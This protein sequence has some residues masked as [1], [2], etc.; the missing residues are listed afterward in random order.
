MKVHELKK[1]II[2]EYKSSTLRELGIKYE[3]DPRTISKYLK[4]NGVYINPNGKTSLNSNLFEVINT[5][6]DAYWLGF[7]YA[8]GCVMG[9]NKLELSLQALDKPHLEKFK[10]YLKWDGN[11]TFNKVSNSWRVAIMDSVL[12]GNLIDRGCVNRKSL[13][14]NFPSESL[15]PLHLQRH[16]IRGYFD[17]D[18][19][20]HLN[21]YK[22][23]KRYTGKCSVVGT[24]E[25]IKEMLKVLIENTKSSKYTFRKRISKNPNHHT[26]Y[27]IDSFASRNRFDFL[28]YL[29]KD[30]NIYLDRKYN[31]YKKIA[32]HDSNIMDN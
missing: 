26:L 30:S 32:V 18:G 2:D 17:G 5:E 16:F 10:D 31:N 3:C 6:E 4:L 11:L 7:L 20:I 9:T 12:V 21:Y 27:F 28:D 19:S 1:E 24:E 14:L 13:I 8:D 25:F 23:V 15:V 29:Y 22:K